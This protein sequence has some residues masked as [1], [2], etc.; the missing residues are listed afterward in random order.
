M[1]S[2]MKR[3]RRPHCLQGGGDIGGG[4]E[5]QRGQRQ[6]VHQCQAGASPQGERW[7]PVRGVAQDGDIAHGP[8]RAA[9]DAIGILRVMADAASTSNRDRSSGKRRDQS[10]TSSGSRA[11]RVS[12]AGATM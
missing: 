6:G 3:T 7:Q 1:R 12:A 5:H 4:I 8:A 2:L 9:D 11:A 10:S